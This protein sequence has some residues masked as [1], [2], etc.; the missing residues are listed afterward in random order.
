MIGRKGLVAG[1]CAI[2]GIAG[3]V[4]LDR[5][6]PRAPD[7]V[8]TGPTASRVLTKIG[9]GGTA[10][11]FDN[12]PPS[13]AGI[14]SARDLPVESG[15]GGDAPPAG[16][17]I[18]LPPLKNPL[19]ARGRIERVYVR[20][21]QGMLVELAVANAEQRDGWRYA[22]IDFPDPLANGATKALALMTGDMS[23]LGV[24]DVVEMRFAPKAPPQSWEPSSSWAS[25]GTR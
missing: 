5:V 11:L 13:G 1:L 25:S 18:T 21:A 22:S 2:V 16:A 10:S 3:Y 15:T 6:A 19:L 24:G 9:E 17:E 20:V 12:L 8:L 23:E 14:P 7:D 4:Y